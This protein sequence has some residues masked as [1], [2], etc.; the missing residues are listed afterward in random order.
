MSTYRYLN[1][2]DNINALL[3]N[4]DKQDKQ[5]IKTSNRFF[6]LIPSSSKYKCLA[7]SVTHHINYNIQK[8]EELL[9]KNISNKVKEQVFK[10]IMI[11]FVWLIQDN[12]RKITN[13]DILSI[14]DTYYT[15]VVKNSLFIIGSGKNVCT[16]K[17]LE[18]RLKTAILNNKILRQFMKTFIC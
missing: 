2:L 10:E 16:Y 8:L 11:E 13:Q 9:C 1:K 15:M 6:G 5:N 12:L 17:L 7:I 3:K 4:L 18:L 14:T